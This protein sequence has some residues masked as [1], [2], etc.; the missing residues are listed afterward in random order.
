MGTLIRF[1]RMADLPGILQCLEALA[2]VE[3]SAQAAYHVWEE[4]VR[5]SGMLYVVQVDARVVG[6]ATLILERKL[7][8]GG[9][10]AA[11]I[12]DVA[13]LKEEQRKGYG[14]LLVAYVAQEAKDC[15]AYKVTLSCS[16]DHERFYERIGFKCYETEMRIDSK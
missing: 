12:E 3:I 6:T 13:I 9:G 4:M 11:R 15:G 10:V 7:I 8:H 14:T 1:A 16:K 5:R 2:P